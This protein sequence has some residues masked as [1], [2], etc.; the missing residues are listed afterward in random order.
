M[1]THVTNER[2]QQLQYTTEQ[3]QVT[4]IDEGARLAHYLLDVCASCTDDCSDRRVRHTDLKWL[5]HRLTAHNGACPT[6][7]HRAACPAATHEPIVA[8]HL[9]TDTRHTHT[10]NGPFSRTTQVSRY[11][12]CKTNLDF[13][14]ARDKWV[15][16]ASAGPYASLH[17]APDRQPHQHPTTL[18]LQSG[19]PSCRPTNSVEALKAPDTREAISICKSSN[20]N[21]R[22]EPP[23]KSATSRILTPETES[24]RRRPH[25]G[26]RMSLLMLA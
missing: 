10:F 6:P 26:V 1:L 11:Q 3:Q 7:G 19:C 22:G 24:V 13:T 20:T 25:L 21:G 5:V 15:A 17:P 2:R 4:H 23:A 9:H 18:F 16:E 8:L 12:K 14:E